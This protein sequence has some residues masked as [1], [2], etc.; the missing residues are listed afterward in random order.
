MSW[1]KKIISSY[2]EGEKLPSEALV[3]FFKRAKENKFNS[4]ITLNDRV[5]DEAEILD[6]KVKEGKIEGKLF[7]IPV[8]VKDNILVKNLRV[9]CA[10]KILENYIAPYDATVIERIKKEGALIIGKTNLDEFAMGSSN[11]YSYFGPAYNPYD[12]ERVPGGSSGGSAISVAN[13]EAVLSL[14]SDTGG[15][16]RLPA[17]FCNVYG[18]KPTYGAVSRYGLI[19]FASSLDQIGP[20]SKYIEDLEIIFDV[21]KGKDER[22]NTSVKYPDLKVE[23]KY[24]LK[25]GVL[26]DSFSD[27]VEDEIKEKLDEFIL[28]LEKEGI[29]KFSEFEME[30]FEYAIAV[31]YIVACAEASSNLARYD[32]VRYG[33]KK[34]GESLLSMYEE[35]RTLGFGEEVKRRILTG[36]FVLKSGYYEEYYL[37]A[38]KA[39]TKILKE[40]MKNFEKFD[41]LLSPV[42]PTLP[43]K[44]GE[45]INDPVTMYLSDIFT[46]PVNLAG[47][48]AIAFPY[49]FSKNN[50]P[51]GFQFIGK[52]FDEYLF[53]SILKK[54]ENLFN[55]G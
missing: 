14:G 51:I 19:A 42:S 24:P 2:K 11:E 3:D 52:F 34:G 48:P 15:S 35:T 20:F 50:L 40:F 43:F 22:D 41:L 9:T 13:S 26:K 8:S 17:S 49:S 28:V 1:V 46:V 36:T 12:T 39:R 18:L 54:I 5:F 45:K 6:R 30:S 29:A 33:F 55:L 37:K 25:I 21:I 53:F 44:I 27:K 7:G 10:S 16:V 38:Q 23:I 31:Y 4:F 32:G 47:L